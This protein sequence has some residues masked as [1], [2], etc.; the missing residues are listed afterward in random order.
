MV[1]WILVA[2]AF[3]LSF[4]FNDANAAR[5]LVTDLMARPPAGSGAPAMSALALE[6][7]MR[8]AQELDRT[9]TA[10]DYEIARI[11]REAAEGVLL[12]NQINA[13][14]PMLGDYDEPALNAFQRRVIRHDELAKKFQ[15]E[16]PLYPAKTEG[17]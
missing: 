12:Q 17:L 5:T 6:A 16:F 7:C 11:D 3:V 8:R 14:L 2:T 4:G 9:G 15:A 10:I 13:E 1:R